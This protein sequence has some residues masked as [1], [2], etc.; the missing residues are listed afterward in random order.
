MSE[1]SVMLPESI[2]VQAESLA[3]REGVPLE[4]FVACAVTEKVAML[5]AATALQEDG[6]QGRWDGFDAFMAKVPNR[7]PEEYDRLSPKGAAAFE[8]LK[9]RFARGDAG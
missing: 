9:K 6:H 4:T 1:L 3:Q 2:R 5:Q 8:R 7:E